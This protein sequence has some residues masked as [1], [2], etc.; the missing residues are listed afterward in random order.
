V[1]FADWSKVALLASTLVVSFAFGVACGMYRI[2]PYGVLKEAYGTAVDLHDHWDSYRGR[3]PTRWLR[4]ATRAGAGV[5]IA[6]PEH[7]EDGWTFISSLFNG[8]VGLRLIGP[9]GRT[10]HSWRA[11]YLDLWSP[12]ERAMLRSPLYNWDVGIMGAVLLPDASVIFTFNNGGLVKLDK[13]GNVLWKHPYLT[14]HSI[15]QSE[16]GTFWIPGAK[17]LIPLGQPTHLDP[18]V[19]PLIEETILQVDSQGI[20]LREISVP[21]L[22]LENGLESI[23]L[24]NGVTATVNLT[25]D[26]T[27]LNKVAVLQSADAA[28]FPLFKAGDVLVSLRNLNLIFVFDPATQK[29]KWYQVGPWLRQHDPRFTHDGRIS[30]Y[31]NH[32]DNA[33]G[34]RFGGSRIVSID[35]STREAKVV[36][37]GSAASP[38]YS[39]KEGQHV[40]L[41]NGDLLISESM[42]GR[43]FEVDRDGEIVWEFIN[44]YDDKQVIAET[45]AYGRFTPRYFQSV[46]FACRGS[47]NGS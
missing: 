4:P 39:D 46:D 20:L 47:E 7:Y 17:P 29:I 33:D 1:R 3:A 22:M 26:Y 41:D 2:F 42:A 43:I 25:D 13:C 24:A 40:Y 23:L 12:A 44:R 31:D 30:V 14:H 37:A 11:R 18:L 27:H 38:F 5:T 35:P 32:T 34:R 21:K 6:K 45:H 19:A 15:F 9:D 36:Y 10:L 8:D 16:D 28:A